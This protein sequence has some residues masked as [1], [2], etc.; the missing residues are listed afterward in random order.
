MILTA[1]QAFFAC[2]D[3]PF[4]KDSKLETLNPSLLCK[5]S[6]DFLRIMLMPSIG[7]IQFLFSEHSAL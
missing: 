7:F 1:A 6:E 5:E 4:Q 3:V 2:T